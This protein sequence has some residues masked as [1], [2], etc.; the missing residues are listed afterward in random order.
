M[1]VTTLAAVPKHRV[2]LLGHANADVLALEPP[3][4][5]PPPREDEP[6]VDDEDAPQERAAVCA[7]AVFAPDTVFLVCQAYFARPCA[8]GRCPSR[9]CT[10][11]SADPRSAPGGVQILISALSALQIARSSAAE[12]THAEQILCDAKQALAALDAQQHKGRGDPALASRLQ[13]SL[14]KALGVV[15]HTDAFLDGFAPPR[16]AARKR[17][18][19]R[20]RR[21]KK[22]AVASGVAGLEERA[23]TDAA[24]QAAMVE[25]KWGRSVC[26]RA[27][28]DLAPTRPLGSAGSEPLGPLGFQSRKPPATTAR[29]P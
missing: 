28:V 1:Q 16:V 5:P 27:A 19:R 8:L 22:P 10:S 24:L 21:R 9:A 14:R 11:S 6:C 7:L 12:S 25:Y 15:G 3:P 26:T 13:P 17:G 29:V 4:T 20:R 2:P 18:K 23:A